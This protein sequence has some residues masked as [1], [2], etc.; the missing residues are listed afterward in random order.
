M[1]CST[2]KQPVTAVLAAI[3]MLSQNILAEGTN[4][5]AGNAAIP[6]GIGP[7][8]S[9][10]PVWLSEA[11]LEIREGY[12]NNVYRGGSGRNFVSPPYRLPPG[13]VAAVGGVGSFFTTVSP[14]VDIN[15]ATLL[16][17]PEVL[18][19]LSLT[20]APDFFQYRDAP[21]ENYSAQRIATA[22]AGKIDSV[23]YRLDNSFVYIDGSKTAE[24]YPGSY[25]SCFGEGT[26]RERLNQTQE[27]SVLAVQYDQDRWF[28]RPTASL[29][30]YHLN[31]EL[32]PNG[33]SGSTPG[34]M[35][36]VDRSDFN[37][38]ADVGY[39]L[40]HDFALTLGYRD[41]HQYQQKLPEAIDPYG[42]SSSS[43]YQRL[44]FGLEG[45]LTTWLSVKY[46]GGPD[47]RNYSDAAP[48]SNHD[49]VKYFGEG[50]LAATITT[51]DALSFSYLQQQW[52]SGLGRY[53]SYQKTFALNYRHAFCDQ[54]SANL[55]A[56]LLTSDF[57]EGRVLSGPVTTP[58]S[59][60]NYRSDRLYAV[61]ARL[62]YDVTANL[63][64]DVAYALDLGRNEE[65]R[66]DL[67]LASGTQLPATKR[68]FEDQIV[69]MGAKVRF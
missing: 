21:I 8:G 68:Q 50:A 14:K 52:V 57:T 69:S 31:T 23:S 61:T 17:Q 19:V 33:S 41:G 22:I 53:P 59:L 6:F 49:P 65:P 39:R 27:R 37:G 63:S 30:E 16:G 58:T 38:G 44:L 28:L 1:D 54:L 18:R 29:L 67:A 35:N 3:V 32:F 43:D 46:Q 20:Y 55:G 56:S 48:V 51:N 60:P 42:L 2:A 24:S 34:Y 13:G 15:L 47:F 7:W 26:L 25:Y 62:R 66:T 4:F 36:Y 64:V 11:S 9:Q 45:N 40:N 10:R 5:P 12:D